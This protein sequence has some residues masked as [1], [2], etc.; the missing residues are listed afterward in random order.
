LAVNSQTYWYL[1]RG[2]GAVALLLLSTVVVL[3]TLGPTRVGGTRRWPRFALARLHRD[4]SLLTLA[5][6]AVHILTSVLDT[7]AP[8]GW[9]DAII[10]LHSAYR[11]VWLGCGAAAFDLLLALVITSLVRRRLGYT[12]WRR[13]H[14]LAYASWPIAVL[15]GLGTGSDVRAVWLQW[16]TIG[17]TLAVVLAIC[18]RIA[19]SRVATPGARLGWASLALLTPLGIGVFAL[20]GPLRIGWAGHAGTPAALLRTSVRSTRN[21]RAL[22]SN[23]ARARTFSATLTGSISRSTVTGGALVDLLLRMSGGAPGVLRVRLAGKPL[24]TG[25]ISLVG[26]QVDLSAPSVGGVLAGSV[27]SLQGRRF[28]ARVTKTGGLAYELYADLEIDSSTGA[29]RGRLRAVPVSA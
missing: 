21:Q 12:R 8:I 5:V 24:P 9:L 22:R 1:T 19:R 2:S 26:S 11:P 6:L 25:G 16:M 4:L 27:D 10:P 15:H 7:F 13:V 23:S 3:G 17:C 28:R 20:A 18:V 29:V 14:W